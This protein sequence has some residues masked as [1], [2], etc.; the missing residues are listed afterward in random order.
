MF[1]K[2][3]REQVSFH[4]YQYEPIVWAPV[5]N[6]SV[7]KCFMCGNR[8]AVPASSQDYVIMVK[9]KS[10][11]PPAE[12]T[13]GTIQQSFLSWSFGFAPSPNIGGC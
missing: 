9:G 8:L 1:G 3:G 6:A 2:F 5:V 10:E 13:K 12:G 11:Q 7:A 4:A